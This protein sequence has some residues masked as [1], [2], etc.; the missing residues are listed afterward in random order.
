VFVSKV[1]WGKGIDMVEDYKVEYN[2]LLL[3]TIVVIA[4]MFYSRLDT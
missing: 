3:S 2:F 1:R 4:I